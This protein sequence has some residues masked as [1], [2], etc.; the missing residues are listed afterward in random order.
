MPT[1]RSAHL[2]EFAAAVLRAVEV[3]DEDAWLVA[4]SLVQADCWGHQSH[5]LLRLPWYVD[6]IRSGVMQ[7]RTRSELVVDAGCVAVLDGHD[8][9]GQ[10]L[11]AQ[12]ATTAVDRAEQH[13]VGAVAVRSSGHFGTA[14]YFTRMAAQRGCIGILTTNSSPAMA[15]WGGREKAVG[16][17][18]WSI[19]APA[20]RHGCTIVDISNSVVAR[21]K[22]YLAHQEGR[23]V[24]DTWAISAD[25][26]R[27]TDPLTAL[28]GTILPMGG[29]KGYAI[30]FMLD[31]LSGVLTGSSFGRGVHG[32]YQAEQPSGAGHLFLALDVRRFL[33]L[34]E[35]EARVAALVAEVKSV[36]LAQG[37]EEVYYPWELEQ[38]HAARVAERGLELPDRTVSDLERLAVELG[39]PDRP[40]AGA[41]GPRTA[42]A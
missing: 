41:A 26:A 15:P 5:G 17:N 35:F 3:P 18:P 1:T 20:G 7:P 28:A 40:W 2:V 21:G 33:P 16:S 14:A 42:T 11:T 27:T 4:D 24:P 22:I 39:L 38:R 30:S 6:R 13:G 10:V 12:A 32:P 25:G 36:P 19:A 8:G 29:H 23:E 31:V 9:I 34:E 37:H